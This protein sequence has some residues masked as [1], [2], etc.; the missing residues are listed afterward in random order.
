MYI[1]IVCVALQTL[2]VSQNRFSSFPDVLLGL[3]LTSLDMSSNSVT[4]AAVND[5]LCTFAM[6]VVL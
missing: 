6:R 4:A 5:T 1:S 3:S 2:D